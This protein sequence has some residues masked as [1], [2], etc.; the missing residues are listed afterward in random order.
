MSEEWSFEKDDFLTTT[1]YEALYAYHKEPFTHAAKME[2]LAAYSVSKGFKGFKT[3]Y[4]KYVESLKA[5]SGT[6]YIDNVTNFT[7]QPLELNAGDWEADDS[8]IFKKNGYNDEVACPHPIMPVERLVNIDTGEEKLQLAFRKGTIWRKIIVSKT[9]LASSNKVTELAGSGIAVTSQNARAFIQYISDMENMNYYLIPE[10]KSIGRF[11]YIPDEGFSPFVDGLIF[12]GDANFKAMFQTV[13]SR[14]SEAKWLETA[15]EVREMSTTAKIILA[16]SFASVLL[17][18]LNCLPFFVHLWGVDSGTGKT[19]ALMVA[20]SVWGDPAVGA[21]VKTFDGTVV[22]ME[23]TAAFLNN[24]PF[25]LDELQLAKDSKGRTTFDV[26]KLAQGVG[27]T[28]GNRSGGVDLTPTWRNC[29][30][31][32]GESPLTGT[33]SGAG[34]VN[35]V[36]DIECKSAQAVIKDG[37]R[38]SGAVKRNYGFAGRKFVE[39]LYQPGV[40][41]QVSERYRELFRILSDRDTTEKQAMAAAAIILADELACQWIFSG[42]QPLTIEQV[43]EFLAS[44]AAVSAGDRGYKYLCDWVTQNSNKLCGRSENPN[45]E[46]LGAL[47]DGRAYNG[48]VNFLTIG[49]GVLTGSTAAASAAQFTYN[50]ALL[51]SPVTWVVMMLAVLV[52]ALYAGVAAFNKFTGSGVSATGILMGAFAVLGAHVLNNT[53]IPLQNGF[54]MF[55]NFIGNLFNDPVAAVK[56]LFYDMA[57]TVLGYIS[58]MASGIE[59]L[60][61]KIPGVTVDITSGLDSFYAKLESAQQKVKDKSGWVEYV[62][63]MDYIDYSKAAGAGYRFGEGLADKVSGMFSGS[64]YAGLGDIAG[65]VSD[66]AANTGKIADEVHIADEDLQFFR[67]VAEM[68]YI[69]NFVTLTPTVSMSASISEKVDVNGVIQK[70]EQVLK[71]EIA[72]SAEVV[73]A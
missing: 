1:P 39:R 42:Q 19:V 46:V 69:Q 62:K 65:G 31:T 14:G 54:A 4:K 24:L 18:P 28:R 6:I 60:I 3:M 70:I 63:K 26:Y 52:A 58:K 50:S 34:A 59:T 32:T 49:Y 55:A 67:D 30:L 51:A 66:I 64:D 5:Q 2:E 41:D 40:I 11:G 48:L 53:I 44:K 29:I 21:Y 36:I 72:E 13:R 20:A 27:R 8:G 43:S 37:M 15:A 57:L 7:N 45:I 61:N 33:A 17:E 25:C 12:D 71:E 35:R 38:I 73:L 23:K 22:G 68:R 47:E 56:V 16:A 10:K 9:V